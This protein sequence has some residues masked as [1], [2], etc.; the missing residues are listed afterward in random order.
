MISQSSRLVSRVAAPVLRRSFASSVVRRDALQELYIKELKAY[1]APVIKASDSVG[2]VKPWIA[3]AAPAIP[4]VEAFAAA[5]LAEY[6]T[7]VVEVEGIAA[8]EEVPTEDLDDWFV[9]EPLED[10]HH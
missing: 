4:A 2:Q 3:P 9:V 10:A 7:Q 5:D 1:K 6:D 8:V